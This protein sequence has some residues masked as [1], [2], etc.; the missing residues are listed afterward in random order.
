MHTETNFSEP[1]AVGWLQKEWAN[2][3]RLKQDGVPIVGFTWYSL[4]DQVDWDTS[5]RENNNQV[6]KLGLYDL[7][8]QIR[9]VG[10]AYKVLIS[11]WREVLTSECYG[12]NIYNF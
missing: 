2:V 1:G 8:R 12:L 6:N 9:P 10:D 3:Y 11:K 4:I 5:L 7:K